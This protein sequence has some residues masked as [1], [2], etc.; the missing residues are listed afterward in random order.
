VRIHFLDNSSKVFL[1]NDQL[2]IKDLLGQ[3]LSKLGVAEADVVLPYFGLFE[4]RNGASI[5]GVLAMDATIQSVLQSWQSASVEKT[6]KFLFMIRLQLP[7]LWGLQM[8]D[9]VANSLGKEESDLS[10]AEYFQSADLVDPNIL[11]LQFIQAVYNVIT[12]RYP[13]T[14]EEGLTLGAIHF[15]LKFGKYKSDKHKAGFLGNR[16]VEFVPIKLLKSAV[17]GK[18]GDLAQ[19]E[20]QLFERVKVLSL[21]CVEDNKNKSEKTGDTEED[22]GNGESEAAADDDQKNVLF[23]VETSSNFRV[24]PPERKYMEIIYAMSPVYGSTFYKCSQRCNKL[25][26]TVN[27]GIHH[28]GI[29]IFDKSKKHI[30]TFYIQEILRWGFK[31][32]QMFYFEVNPDNEFGVGSFEFDTQEGKA[33]SDLMTD[34]AMAFLKERERQDERVKHFIPVTKNKVLNKGTTA[35]PK[36]TGSVVNR[37]GYGP[38]HHRASVKFQALFRGYSLRNEWIKE[39]AAILLQ[40][41]YRGYQARVKLSQMIEQMIKRGEL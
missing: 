33:I 19:W 36:K 6:A 27:I 40:S 41:I 20:T 12:G 22:G 8:R 5:D 35:A 23:R 7:S 14:Q 31:P 21:D 29:H 9:I 39:D 32:N 30:K 18:G 10:N 2:S 37:D 16:I 1:I 34:Y 38:E 3:C 25:P 15:I 11:H 24:V 4:S 17:N 28:D 13:T 26:D